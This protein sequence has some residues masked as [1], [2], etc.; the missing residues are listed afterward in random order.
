MN[1]MQ[2]VRWRI[3]MVAGLPQFHPPAGPLEPINGLA[4]RQM[5]DEDLEW[6]IAMTR[7]RD[8][9]VCRTIRGAL[10]SKSAGRRERSR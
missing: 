1:Q 2:S 10:S 3:Q 9:G 7:D 6:M 4:L 8:A 5:S